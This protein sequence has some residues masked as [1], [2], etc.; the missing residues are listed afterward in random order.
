[1]FAGSIILYP[2]VGFIT[3]R[4]HRR[5]TIYRLCLLASTLTLLGYFW[6][7]LPPH[8]THTALPAVCFFTL[9]QGFAS[10]LLVLIVPK[11]VPQRYVPT[12]LGAHKSIEQTGATVSV[13]FAGYLLDI[14]NTSH[15]G[16]KPSSPRSDSSVVS[17]A[18]GGLPTPEAV[19]RL[20]CWFALFNVLQFISIYFL[21]AIDS[22]RQSTE[23]VI[24]SGS[25]TPSY[26]PLS[27][28]EPSEDHVSVKAVDPE[29]DDELSDEDDQNG[30]VSPNS[31]A[32]RRPSMHSDER[33]F[34]IPDRRRLRGV[35]NIVDVTSTEYF[36][37]KVFYAVSGATIIGAWIFYVVSLVL[38]FQRKS[39]GGT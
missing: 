2:I 20:L 4:F 23:P 39:S 29:E 36:R 7:L 35:G 38:D 5:S 26:R 6:L 17:N 16:S 27:S 34:G 28:E 37:G 9:G 10:L 14:R 13:T 18:P 21:W 19:F 12:A 8:L 30:R 3:D 32:M 11:I 33:L 31:Y 15:S 1:L 24:P 25:E 22:T